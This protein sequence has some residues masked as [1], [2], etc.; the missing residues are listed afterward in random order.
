MGDKHWSGMMLSVNS[1]R[2]CVLPCVISEITEI[3][4]SQILTGVIKT[5]KLNL[6]PLSDKTQNC[7]L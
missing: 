7:W 4:K 5:I 2:I 1:V 3:N 6:F